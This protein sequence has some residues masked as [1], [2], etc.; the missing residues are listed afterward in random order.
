MEIKKS[1]KADLQNKKGLFLEIGLIVALLAV[2]AAFLY[3]PKEYRIKKVDNNYGPVEEEITEITRNEQK[4]PEQPQKVEVK[5]F[6]DILDIVTNDAKITTDISFED[7]ADDLEITTQ[8]VEVE[9]EEIEDD[10]PFIKVEKMPSFQGGDLNKF[11]NWVQ[12]RVRYPQIAQENGVSGKVV[13]SFVVEKDG[14]LTNI[15]VLQSPDR[16]LADEAVR[17]LKT[18]PKWEPGQQ[19]NQPV[20]VKYTLP[21]DFRIQN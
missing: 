7:F 21:V 8:V 2:I 13:L 4:P 5:V 19:R 18:S 20:R 17:V 11:R 10:Q 9:E 3:T 16:S 1:P 6:N 12:E 15:E 14:T